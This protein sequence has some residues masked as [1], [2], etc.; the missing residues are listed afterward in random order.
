MVITYHGVGFVKVQFSDI[1]IAVNP[2][3][4]E[5]KHR[6]PKFGADI[7]IVSLD[8]PD[9][10]GVPQLAYGGKEP[11]LIQGP[12][13]YEVKGVFIKGFPGVS[14]YGGKEIMNTI[15]AVSLEGMNL[16]FLG[17][18]EDPA[19]EGKTKEALDAVDILFVPIGGE[20]VLS[21]Q[22]AYKLSVSL[23]PKIIVPIF[24]EGKSALDAF[25]KEGGVTTSE[26]V[27]KLTVKRR[28]LESKGG[29]IVVL[30]SLS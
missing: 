27:E 23:E 15:Y 11:F 13:E 25:K 14:H 18:L 28:D 22:V 20:G 17:A 8:H 1:T 21:S 2:I 29:E 19:L 3:A 7:G 26:P 24:F 12:G 30:T 6:S 9:C 4:K 10:N 16:C 5:S